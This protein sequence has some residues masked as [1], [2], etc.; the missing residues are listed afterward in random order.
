MPDLADILR[1][2]NLEVHFPIRGG[3]LDRILGQPARAIRAVDGIDLAI[4]R[5]E[6][7]ALVGESGSGKTT[8]GRVIAK[9]SR[10][11]GGRLLF[12]GSDITS[13]RRCSTL[14]PYRR[15]VQMIFQDAYQALNPRH[16]VF[17][18]VAEPLRS[19]RL[20]DNG[21]ELTGRVSEALAAAGLNPPG[22]FFSRF[23]HELSGGQRQRVVIAGALAVQPEFI[24]AD[25]PVSMLDV[26]IRAQI[27]QT[28]VDL[29]AKHNM[30]FL[31]ITHDLPLASLI[32]DRI[33]VLYLGK[34]VEIGDADEV[35]MNP[36][37]PYT[38]ALS[39]ATPKVGRGTHNV[40]RPALQG[41]VP[42]AA[43]VPMGCRFHPRCP[44]A[45]DRC[46]QESPPAVLVGPRH[47]AA[48]WRADE[49]QTT[50]PEPFEKSNGRQAVE[51]S[52]G[53]GN[54]GR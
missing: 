39:N 40:D 17:D 36:R 30:A 51:K 26:S 20:V 3:F 53:R 4:A 29:R 50:F 42:S 48:C 11:T 1:L 45:I 2:E 27:I 10:P 38:V 34:L 31:F 43:R 35:T 19:M 14:R 24:V 49:I 46:R 12:G 15:R 32:A 52:V 21:R 23:P 33:A 8:V 5:G 7:V 47:I 41:E 22:D 44:M 54:P 28:L 13:L 16:T 37:H 9:L 6:I 25:E 18:A